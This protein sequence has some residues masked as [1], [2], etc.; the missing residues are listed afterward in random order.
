MVMEIA[1]APGT[2]AIW[3]MM[4]RYEARREENWERKRAMLLSWVDELERDD[5]YGDP[6]T[7]KGPR[8]AQ[9]RKWW[10]DQGEPDIV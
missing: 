9:I 8:T 7:G 2:A 4:C 1:V 6:A 10:R 5:G 3:E